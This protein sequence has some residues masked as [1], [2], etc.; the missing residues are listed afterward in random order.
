MAG[1]P[2][3]GCTP[4]ERI[5]NETLA[6][7]EELNFWVMKYNNDLKSSLEMFK[8]E[9][10]DTNYSYFDTYNALSDFIQNPDKYGTLH[11][12]LFFIFSII[13]YV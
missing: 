5:Q 1:V 11:T 12:F 9:F 8:S 10:S 4:K 3:V 2:V 7:H 6:C 13:K